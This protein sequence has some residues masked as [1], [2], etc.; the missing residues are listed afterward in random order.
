LSSMC[1]EG[2]CA[3]FTASAVLIRDCCGLLC[4]SCG[5]CCVVHE[6]FM[7]GSCGRE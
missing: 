6:R 4:S 5:D 2:G 3:L 7:C 1:S